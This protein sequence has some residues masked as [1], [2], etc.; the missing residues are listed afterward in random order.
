[1]DSLDHQAQPPMYSHAVSSPENILRAGLKLKT[2]AS[3]VKHEIANH[4][5]NNFKLMCEF[6]LDYVIGKA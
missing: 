1:M 5:K 4:F 3:E 6:L 2:I